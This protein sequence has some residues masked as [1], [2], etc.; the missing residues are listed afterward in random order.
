[1]ENQSL[2]S[3]LLSAL[4]LAASL[5]GDAPLLKELVLNGDEGRLGFPNLSEEIEERFLGQPLT[6][7]TISDIKSYI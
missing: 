3:Y 5:F 2:Q 6:K 1:M 4:M 7:E